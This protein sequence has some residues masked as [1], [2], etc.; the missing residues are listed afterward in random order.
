MPEDSFFDVS[1]FDGLLE[2]ICDVASVYVMSDGTCDVPSLDEVSQEPPSDTMVD[3]SSEI[4]S[5][6]TKEGGDLMGVLSL[7]NGDLVL[8]SDTSHKGL[9]WRGLKMSSM[10]VTA[11][12]FVFFDGFSFFS[13]DCT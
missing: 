4:T 3:S 6:C 7:R 10:S 11:A 12:S 2:D 5:E 13:R 9:T 1:S 8:C